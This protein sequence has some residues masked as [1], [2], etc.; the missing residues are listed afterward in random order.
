MISSHSGM[1]M[2]DLYSMQ[3]EHLEAV[4]QLDG[5]CFTDD[6]FAASWWQKAVA[7]KGACGW[8]LA[9]EGEPVAYC[10]FSTV[11]DEAELLRIAVDPDRQGQGLGGSLL[12]QVQSRLARQGLARLFLEVRA[13]NRVAQRLYQRCGWHPCGRRK[14]Y[15]PLGSGHEDALLFSWQP[16]SGSDTE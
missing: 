15:Y 6:P 8:I 16:A 14:N 4:R 9:Q 3:A 5:R 1:Y 10:L 7:M 13:S 2:A 12:R 11:L